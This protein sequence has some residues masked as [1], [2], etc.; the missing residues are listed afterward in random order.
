ML[1]FLTKGLTTGWRNLLAAPDLAVDLGTANTRLYVRGH[2]LIADEPTLIKI[3]PETGAVEAVGAR[4]ARLSKL[5]QFA[6]SIS[7]LHAG[8]VADVEAASSL[9]KFLLSRAQKL[10]ILKPRALACAPTD[11]CD[12]EREALIEVTRRA[13]ASA[14]VVVPEPLAAAIGAG[15]DVSSPYAQML[16]DIG[17]GVTDIAIIRSGTLITTSAVRTACSDLRHCVAQMIA[18]RYGVLLFPDEAE[19]LTR[20]VGASRDYERE[21]LFLTEGTDLLTGEPMSLCISSHDVMEAIE[22]PLEIIIDAIH[23]AVRDLPLQTSCEVIENGI[24]LTGGGAQLHGMSDRLAKATS[25]SVRAAD[26]PMRAV[27][28]GACQMLKVG[29]ATRIWTN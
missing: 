20:M 5:D 12:E 25:L 28:N 18:F 8:V 3:Q 16:V 19:R 7:P 6:Y 24:C 26:D 9:L 23:K 11:A 10:G 27:I 1:T 2:G 13:G 22:Q 29:I 21:R 14:V 17:D 15:L 4:A